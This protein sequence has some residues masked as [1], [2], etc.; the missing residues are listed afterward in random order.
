MNIL[1]ITHSINPTLGGVSRVTMTLAKEL[2]MRGNV[3]S[4]IY[5]DGGGNGVAKERCLRISP[6]NEKLA[7]VSQALEYTHKNAIECIINQDNY[8]TAIVR[9]LRK[10]RKN[11]VKVVNVLHIE[12]NF[13]PYIKHKGI[14]TKIKDLIYKLIYREGILMKQRCDMLALADKFVLLSPSYI[15]PFMRTYKVIDV[16]R[17]ICSIPNPTPLDYYEAPFEKKGNV[18]LVV[19]RIEDNQK[20]ITTALK[21]W[22]QVERQIPE[23]HLVLAGHGEDEMRIIDYAKELGLC[24]FRFVGRTDDPRSL[25]AT[26]SI[27]MM[28]SRYEGL[29][30]TLLESMQFGCVPIAFDAFLSVHDIIEDGE[31][32][33]LA[34]DGNEEDFIHKLLQLIN[35]K[36]L[37]Q[38]MF[39]RTEYTRQKFSIQRI[40]DKWEQ[41]LKELTSN[42]KE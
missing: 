19:S 17:K 40:V 35:N 34:E 11:N 42:G 8:H 41:L 2:T 26:A 30:M 12:P 25:Y 37:R 31:N 21:I 18:V 24:S 20:R 29:P 36:D 23:W 6:D 33:F 9:F 38:R 13:I 7:F 10:V 22:K 5:W 28:T 32:G 27:F 4:F 14:K 1:F 3:C 15:E 39:E 16:K